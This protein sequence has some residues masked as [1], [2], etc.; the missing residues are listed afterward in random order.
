MFSIILPNLIKIFIYQLLRS[1]YHSKKCNLLIYPNYL[2]MFVK[3]NKDK[4][5]ILIKHSAK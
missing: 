1:K 2:L 3:T 4:Q 5:K